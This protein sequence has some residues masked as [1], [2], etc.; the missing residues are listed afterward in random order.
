MR[1]I[2]NSIR[3]MIGRFKGWDF[4]LDPDYVIREIDN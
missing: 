3:S 1:P 4:V 2:V